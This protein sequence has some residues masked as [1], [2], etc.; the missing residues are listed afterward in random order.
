MT[1]LKNFLALLA[2]GPLSST[3][4]AQ[5]GLEK[6]EW[7][8]VV[9]SEANQRIGFFYALNPDCTNM[10]DLRIRVTKQPQHGTVE[11]MP[12]MLF[13]GYPKENIRAK[14]NQHKVKGIQIN[15]KSAAKYVG[16][17]E[18]EVLVLYPVGTAWEVRYSIDVR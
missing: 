6:K 9:P 11:T 17:D 18:L 16:S 8:R 7:T 10:G 1:P 4:F 13:P 5:E 2:L 15:Y 12:T 3:A 14:C